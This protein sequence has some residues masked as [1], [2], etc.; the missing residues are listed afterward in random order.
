M[1]VSEEANGKTRGWEESQGGGSDHT[2]DAGGA[3]FQFH[4]GADGAGVV[5]LLVRQDELDTLHLLC[6]TTFSDDESDG[7]PTRSGEVGYLGNDRRD[8]VGL[9][10][11]LVFAG[12]GGGTLQSLA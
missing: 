2:F 9:F 3:R 6:P 10:L 7:I 12:L 5:V 8:D 4:L 1:D 11:E